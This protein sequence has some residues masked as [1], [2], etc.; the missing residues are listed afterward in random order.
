MC[1]KVRTALVEDIK[2]LGGIVEVD[3]P[4]IGGL[5]RKKHKEKRG[6]GS[7][8]GG[9]GSGKTPIVGAVRRKGNV[10]P[11]VVENVRASTLEAFVHESRVAH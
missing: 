8:T 6:H 11:R 7:G 2:Q 4:F 9:T 10:V 1:H 3:E 5:A